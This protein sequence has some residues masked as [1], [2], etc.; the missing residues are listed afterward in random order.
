MQLSLN[1]GKTL[2]VIIFRTEKEM[3]KRRD[4]LTSLRTKVA[5][6]ASSLNMSNFGTRDSLL[7]P[8]TKPPDAMSRTTG[9]DNSGIV[10]L[11]RQIM[12]G[13]ILCSKF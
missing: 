7:G 5:Q 3:N 9:L 13:K 12:R 11:Q 4:M 10:G 1:I 8:D 2:L 6:M